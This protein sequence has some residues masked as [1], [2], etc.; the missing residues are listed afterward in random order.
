MP[1][2]QAAVASL[3]LAESMDAHAGTEEEEEH[4]HRTGKDTIA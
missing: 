4:M 3:R 2:L 1:Y